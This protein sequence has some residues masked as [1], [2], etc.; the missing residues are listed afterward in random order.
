MLKQKHT[1][2]QNWHT[3]FPKGTVVVEVPWCTTASCSS[4]WFLL[5][6]NCKISISLL[7]FHKKSFFAA[8][9]LPSTKLFLSKIFTVTY[10][11]RDRYARKSTTETIFE[12]CFSNIFQLL[13]STLQNYLSTFRTTKSITYHLFFWA[14][15]TSLRFRGLLSLNRSLQIILNYLTCFE[16]HHIKRQIAGRVMWVKYLLANSTRTFF[17]LFNK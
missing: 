7:N 13:V 6:N 4:T 9:K 10:F 16:M 12:N 14:F 5:G 8:H 15:K 1:S 11:I 3:N 2:L 17:W